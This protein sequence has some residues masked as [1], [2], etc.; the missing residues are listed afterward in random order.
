MCLTAIPKFDADSFHLLCTNTDF[1]S[2][3][4]VHPVN[5]SA[6]ETDLPWPNADLTWPWIQQDCWSLY[7]QA[8]DHAKVS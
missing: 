8:K 1:K 7:N 4:S 2:N 6:Y 5:A 3:P